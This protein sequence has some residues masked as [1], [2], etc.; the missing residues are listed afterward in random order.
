[1]SYNNSSY[2]SEI[3]FNKILGDIEIYDM[4]DRFSDEFKYLRQDLARGYI[5]RFEYDIQA[6]MMQEFLE[7][8]IY[9]RMNEFDKWFKN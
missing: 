1:M 3:E 2:E 8:Y 5:S 9:I 7:E 4:G 6:E